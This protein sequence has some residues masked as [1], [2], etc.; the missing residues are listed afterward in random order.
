MTIDDWLFENGIA[1]EREPK[2]PA[3]QEHNPTG[4]MRGDWRIGNVYVEYFGLVGDAAY[5]RKIRKK[6]A[7]AEELGIEVFPVYPVDLRALDARMS[8]LCGR[9]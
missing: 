4:R 9:I 5:D 1:H 6:L 8:P 7:L 2:Y 3:H